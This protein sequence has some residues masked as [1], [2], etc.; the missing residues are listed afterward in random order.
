MACVVGEEH[1]RLITLSADTSE[2]VHLLERLA[3]F[4]EVRVLQDLDLTVLEAK[5]FLET[6]ADCLCILV[7]RGQASKVRKLAALLSEVSVLIV[8]DNESA[9]VHR[10]HHVAGHAT[11][12]SMCFSTGF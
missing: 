7:Y 10:N 8:D 3:Q 1:G 4:L 6:L 5:H 2:A 12:Y 11:A 9:P